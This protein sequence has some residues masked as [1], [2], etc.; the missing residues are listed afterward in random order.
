[1][2]II[3]ES[4]KAIFTTWWGLLGIIGI[5]VL[6]GVLFYLRRQESED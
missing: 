2:D 1:M 4:F 3:T 5:V 6:L